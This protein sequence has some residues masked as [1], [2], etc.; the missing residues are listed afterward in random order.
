MRKL[1]LNL[2][3]LCC[4]LTAFCQIPTVGL[5][6]YWPFNGNAN[7]ESSNGNNGTISGATLTTDRFGN[8]NSAY[9][10]DGN[11]DYIT[12]ADNASLKPTKVS[13]SVWVKLNGTTCTQTGGNSDM[14]SVIFKKNSYNS[15]FEGYMIGYRTDLHKFHGL[16]S[17]GSN[18]TCFSNTTTINV[19][20]HIVLT[21]DSNIMKFY[22]NGVLLDSESIGFSLNYGT[23]PLCFGSTQL[24]YNGFFNGVM[25]DI[26][27][28][29]RV[30]TQNEVNK[31]YTGCS[32]F[33]LNDT[34]TY[35]VS[36]ANFQSISPEI[37]Y[38]R[39]D[40]LSTISGCDSVINRFSKFIY[41]PNYFTDSISVEDTLNIKINVSVSSIPD[42][43]EIKLYPNPT[44]DN[45]MIDC[46]DYLKMNNYQIKILN[47]SAS[48]IWS[49]KITQQVY[50]VDLSAYSKGLYFI[51]IDDNTNSK[52][53]TKKIVLY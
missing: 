51:E 33:N 1:F 9:S 21:I 34:T 37:Y 53:I 7:D 42:I 32:N 49:S 31:L 39:T 16:A 13:I 14:A 30:L 17:N 2:I 19:W 25:D 45:L 11:N 22:E 6:G 5:V 28:W 35:F 20:K 38:K 50:N 52:I 24:S 43:N 8:A 26:G 18:A 12:V 47:S 48:V 29:N 3:L 36:S 40:S 41:N 23:T 44:K 27:I 46:G 10:F 4:S 15:C